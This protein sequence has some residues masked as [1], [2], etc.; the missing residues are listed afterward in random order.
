MKGVYNYSQSCHIFQFPNHHVSERL[1]SCYALPHKLFG[2]NFFP[3]LLDV[4]SWRKQGATDLANHSCMGAKF[5]KDCREMCSSSLAVA[6][7]LIV[8]NKNARFSWIFRQT[9][10]TYWNIVPTGMPSIPNDRST[11]CSWSWRLPLCLAKSYMRMVPLCDCCRPQPWGRDSTCWPGHCRNF[12]K[13]CRESKPILHHAGSR[14]NQKRVMTVEWDERHARQLSES[15]KIKERTGMRR[16]IVTV[17]MKLYQVGLPLAWGTEIS[18]LLGKVAWRSWTDLSAVCSLQL[19][20][21][22]TGFVSIVEH[23]VTSAPS[24]YPGFN[25]TATLGPLTFTDFHSGQFEWSSALGT[26]VHTANSL[27]LFGWFCTCWYSASCLALRS[28]HRNARCLRF[29]QPRLVHQVCKTQRKWQSQNCMLQ[30][31][32][33]SCTISTQ[34]LAAG[35]GRIEFLN[36]H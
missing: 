5:H 35:F 17:D 25:W 15:K 6:C 11:C 10:A 18:G 8:W 19:T 9:I 1:Q 31:F 14:Q 2:F 13:P 24:I 30:F 34:A 4:L 12:S 36:L 23:I 16:T 7:R 26:S 22:S 27:W 20:S 29:L 32:A 21:Q 28:C 3:P 33:R